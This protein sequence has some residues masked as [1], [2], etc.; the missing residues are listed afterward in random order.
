MSNP[1]VRAQG[2][3]SLMSRTSEEA[4]LDRRWYACYTRA[5]HEKRV[6]RVLADRGV[7]GFLPLIGH[8][9]EWHDRTKIVHFPLFAGYVFVRISPGEI[10]D[11][12]CVTSVVTMVMVNGRPAP[13]ADEEIDN[14]R[15]FAE[16]LTATGAVPE[17]E[18]LITSGQRVIITSGPFEGVEGI[19]EEVRS[20]SR[21][22]VGLAALGQGFALNVPAH[23]L[24]P[25][26][27]R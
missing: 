3:N 6:A 16:A 20:G 26:G 5:R 19:V 11:V 23:Q 17:P 24:R 14:I 4:A 21:L 18:P 25:L 8:R 2:W 10:V 15:R 22:L 1:R 12:T 13:I 7:E 27:E 9:R